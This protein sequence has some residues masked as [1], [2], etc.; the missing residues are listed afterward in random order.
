M[1]ILRYVLIALLF[2]PLTATAQITLEGV[3]NR[4]L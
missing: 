2:V 4:R 1:T 3:M